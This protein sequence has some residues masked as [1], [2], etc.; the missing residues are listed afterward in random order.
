MHIEEKRQLEIE[1]RKM[2]V[3]YLRNKL[4]LME[5]INEEMIYTKE[6][7]REAV[8]Y[9]RRFRHGD[10][11]EK[12]MYVLIRITYL[13]DFYYAYRFKKSLIKKYWALKE[14]KIKTQRAIDF[15]DPNLKEYL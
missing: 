9:N 4:H 2:E 12:Y 5:K 11:W 8:Q 7:I 6:K 1:L 14:L 10:F 13:I 3:N 15:L